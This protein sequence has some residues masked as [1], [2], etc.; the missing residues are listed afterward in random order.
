VRSF[1]AF[2]ICLLVLSGAWFLTGCATA[3]RD[4]VTD[5]QTSSADGMTG[6]E[7]KQPSPTDDMDSVQKTG[8]YL[9]WLSLDFLCAWAGGTPSFTP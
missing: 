2:C 8:Y 6:I 7:K 5:V 1:R 3:G 4:S 9:G